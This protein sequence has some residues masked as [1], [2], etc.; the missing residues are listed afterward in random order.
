MCREKIPGYKRDYTLEELKAIPQYKES[1]GVPENEEVFYF[2]NIDPKEIDE[3]E[4]FI[5]LKYDEYSLEVSN[6][7]RIRYE[8]KILK[9]VDDENKK[10][11]WLWLDCPEYKKL[12]HSDK[13]YVYQ[14]VADAWLG[15]NP[16][17]KG[18]YYHR[19][20]INNNGYDNR[21]ENLIWLT[22]EEHNQIHSTR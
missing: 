18:G 15:P 14:L 7:G 6:Y 13:A 12:H 3:G 17:K 8:G 21:P 20:H 16:G 4:R 1:F 9:Q 22:R 11:G 5:P 2:Q 10:N 19:H